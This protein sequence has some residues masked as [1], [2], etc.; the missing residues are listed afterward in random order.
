MM[1]T[2]MLVKLLLLNSKQTQI[3]IGK[4]SDIFTASYNQST[5]QLQRQYLQITNVTTKSD[6]KITWVSR[7][8]NTHSNSDMG[9]SLQSKYTRPSLY[10]TSTLGNNT[11][12]LLWRTTPSTA[13]TT[14]AATNYFTLT[15]NYSPHTTIV[16]LTE[17][18]DRLYSKIVAGRPLSQTTERPCH[19]RTHMTRLSRVRSTVHNNWQSYLFL[20]KTGQSTKYVIRP[21]NTFHDLFSI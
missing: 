9:T 11:Q 4:I 16:L 14:D 13:T 12:K 1:F 15:S 21:M 8:V 3:M 20:D 17:L 19:V 18:S 10:D 5:I 7:S 2:G 6:S